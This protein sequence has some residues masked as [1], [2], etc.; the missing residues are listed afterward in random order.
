MPPAMS[1]VLILDNDRAMRE[2]L[3]LA[4]RQGGLQPLAAAT[5]EEA[6][7]HLRAGHADQMLLDLNLG[8]GHSGVTL[9]QRWQGLG[10]LRPFLMLTG[11]PDD[12]A[13]DALHACPGFAGV[14]AKPFAVDQ[15]VERLKQLGAG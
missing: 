3:V 8:G 10:L 9:V 5:A 1:Q 13:L 15:L 4:L 7:Q 2:M 6:E 12:P 11:T 14:L